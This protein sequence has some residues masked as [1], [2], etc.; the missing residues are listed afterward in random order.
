M[1][2][3]LDEFR[4]NSAGHGANKWSCLQIG[5]SGLRTG[6]R[7]RRLAARLDDLYHCNRLDSARLG[8]S[9]GCEL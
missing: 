3:E 7:R 6:C 2:R 5:S 8:P 4:A 1:P 9:P